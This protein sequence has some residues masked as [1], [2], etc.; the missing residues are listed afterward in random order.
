MV[1]KKSNKELPNNSEKTLRWVSTD[2]ADITQWTETLDDIRTN[3]LIHR[4]LQNAHQV[5][6]FL[7]PPDPTQFTASDVG[8][9]GTA[10]D[11][12]LTRIR[13]AIESSESIVVYADYD[14][15][16]I[17]A[18]TIM[19]ETLH[20]LG[21]Q[22]MPYIPHRVEEGYGLS[23]K[24][25]DSIIG[26]YKPTLI[27]T[28]DHGITGAE[29]VAYAQSLGIDVIITDHHTKGATLPECTIVH[30]PEL[31]GAGVSWFVSKELRRIY[32]RHIHT[33]GNT[34]SQNKEHMALAAIGTVADL[35]PLIGPNRSIVKYGLSALN[36]TSRVGLLALIQE[37]GLSPGE[38]AVYNISHGLAPRLNAM[39]RLEHAMDAMRLLCTSQEDRAMLLARK[40]ALTNKDRQQLTVDSALHAKDIVNGR[41]GAG[42]PKLLFVADDSYNQGIIGLI[43]GKLV[44]E[45][46]RPSIVIAK[47][48]LISKASARSISGF[49]I[50]EAI[51]SQSDIL[52]DVGGHPMA[53]GFT[54]ETK[55]L[56]AL[57][58]RLEVLA[59]KQI[60]SGMM[61]KKLRVESEI[62]LSMATTAL[63][64][65]L[66]D[67]QPFGFGNF[68][69]IFVSRD[70]RVL[71]VRSIGKENKHLKLRLGSA[72]TPLTQS[73][74]L[75]AVAFNLGSMAAALQPDTMIDIAYTIDM[76]AWN[77]KT[78]LQLKIKDIHVHLID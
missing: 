6:V 36:E 24:G 70:V 14:A 21:A 76:N 19:W 31:C 2:G 7:H 3:L 52:I 44:E 56:A 25:I 47:G 49:N 41:M 60:N 18:G 15:D 75:D 42:L 13:T 10:L 46:Y 51:R 48:E 33:R 64:E 9:D 22:V 23:Q 55:N 34:D 69:P 63:W 27:V 1:K 28:V 57:Q 73:Q 12:A 8:I 59:E 30:T 17:T 65:L 74:A 16:G 53:A 68:E 62:P 26:L 50:V 58:T 45:F 39:G 29:K 71:Q 61:E 66:Q 67:F 77:G 72:G 37:A 40:I 78:T 35:V 5:E 11:E 54:V 32:K 43:A 4:G 38:L 20:D